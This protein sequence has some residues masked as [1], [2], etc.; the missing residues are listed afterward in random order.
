MYLLYKYNSS[1][2]RNGLLIHTATW[3]NLKNILKEAKRSNE[4]HTVRLHLYETLKKT[5]LNRLLGAG[6]G[7]GGLTG[8]KYKEIF[9]MI[10]VFCILAVVV[11][12]V[13]K[14][15][16]FY[17]TVHLSG[18]ISLWTCLNKVNWKYRVLR[19]ECSTLAVVS[20]VQ[21]IIELLLL[22]I[23]IPC[24]PVNNLLILKNTFILL[25]HIKIIFH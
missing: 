13:Y 18:Y 15:V 6:C 11:T 8:M 24:I 20:P 22:S 12:W 21:N 7:W 5:N 9:G 14:L 10:E 25:I 4:S 1:V 3:L 2:E 16:K 23:W 19:N 17:E